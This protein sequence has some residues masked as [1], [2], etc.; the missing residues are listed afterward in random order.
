MSEKKPF[1]LVITDNE[2]GETLHDYD[3]DCIIGAANQ[4]ESTVC[5][6]TCRDCTVG[7]IIETITGVEE[8]VKEFEKDDPRLGLL[9]EISRRKARKLAEIEEEP[10][11]AEVT[12]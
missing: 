6:G 11:G 3:T 7:D 4:E 12:S 9:L 1:H 8:T 10:D 5:I 2:T